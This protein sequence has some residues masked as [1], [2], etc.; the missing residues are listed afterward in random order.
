MAEVNYNR[1]PTV[2][3]HGVPKSQYDSGQAVGTPGPGGGSG[4]TGIIQDIKAHPVWA[5]SIGI[6]VI[7]I[8]IMVYFWFQGRSSNTSS[9]IDPTT[10]QPYSLEN[11]NNP[12]AMYGSQLDADYQQLISEQNQILGILQQI[13]QGQTGSGTPPPNHPPPHK[14]PKPPSPL[15]K[16]TDFLGPSGVPHYVTTGTETL[17]Q[18]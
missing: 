4:P 17:D 13:Q 15:V 16:G 8:A 5:V 12:Q 7:A 11:G 18:I 9:L 10:G 2:S 3:V 14:W 6:G 1:E